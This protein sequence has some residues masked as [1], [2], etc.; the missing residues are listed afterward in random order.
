MIWVRR[1]PA[2][3]PHRCARPISADLPD[4]RHGDLWRCPICLVLWRIGYGCD[5]CDTY[6]PIPHPGLCQL[7]PRLQWRPARTWQKIIHWRKGRTE[8]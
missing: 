3:G 8:E 1:A 4:G 6:G 2:V 7:W 5:G